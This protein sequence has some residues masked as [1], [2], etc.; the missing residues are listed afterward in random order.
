[1]SRRGRA[2]WAFIADQRI[3]AVVFDQI[4]TFTEV[5][6]YSKKGNNPDDHK[7]RSRRKPSD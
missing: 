2:E 7:G 5:A 1:M 6:A 3:F 4:A